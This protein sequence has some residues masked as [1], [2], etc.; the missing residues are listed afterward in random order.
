MVGCCAFR[1]HARGAVEV[2]LLP[3][4][5]GIVARRAVSCKNLGRRDF[6]EFVVVLRVKRASDEQP[7]AI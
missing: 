5:G 2:Q 7:C 3:F 1:A 6:W 4:V